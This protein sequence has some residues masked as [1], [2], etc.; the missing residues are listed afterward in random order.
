MIPEAAVVPEG[1]SRYVFR[2]E[3]GK[4]VRVDVKLG[5]RRNGEVEVTKGLA[6]GDVVVISGQQRVR[7]GGRVEVINTVDLGV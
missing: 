2:I 1:N 5:L 7:S 3:D 4:A 6:P